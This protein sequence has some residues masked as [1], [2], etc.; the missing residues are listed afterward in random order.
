MRFYALCILCCL[1]MIAVGGCALGGGRDRSVQ[2]LPS[3]WTTLKQSPPD[4]QPS[5]RP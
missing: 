1:L 2:R 5:S 4:D 3:P